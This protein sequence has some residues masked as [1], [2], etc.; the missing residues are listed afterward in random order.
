MGGFGGL[1]MSYPVTMMTDVVLD[2]KESKFAYGR[3]LLHDKSDLRNGIVLEAQEPLP[4]KRV[5][6]RHWIAWRRA[7]GST[8]YEMVGEY[9]TW[10]KTVYVRKPVDTEF[11][12]GGYKY[13]SVMVRQS[14][15]LDP[16]VK[17]DVTFLEWK[18]ALKM[19]PIVVRP[20]PY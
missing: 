1:D 16:T 15:I 6:G 18:T 12:A 20:R 4:G 9:Q 2:E 19:L 17:S 10:Q 3:R 7:L 13:R 14:W 8:N 5:K 11:G